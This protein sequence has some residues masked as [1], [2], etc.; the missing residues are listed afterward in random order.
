MNFESWAAPDFIKYRPI[1]Y[2]GS[3]FVLFAEIRNFFN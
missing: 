3:F 1:N 2:N